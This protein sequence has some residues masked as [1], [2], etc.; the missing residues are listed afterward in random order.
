MGKFQTRGEE[1]N[2]KSRGR[3][4]WEGEIE[5]QGGREERGRE[6]KCRGKKGKEEEEREI[7]R[8]EGMGK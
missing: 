5:K 8:K 1:K 2:G 7:R 4:K 6:E 3:I